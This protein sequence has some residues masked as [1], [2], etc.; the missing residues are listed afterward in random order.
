MIGVK[1]TLLGIAIIL[2]SIALGITGSTSIVAPL[3][4]LGLLTAI[5]GLLGKDS[6][7]CKTTPKE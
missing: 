4:I 1:V 2:F 5:L 3:A 6:I 7:E